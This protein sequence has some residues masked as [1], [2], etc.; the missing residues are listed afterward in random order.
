M[1]GLLRT[2]AVLSALETVSVLALLANLG[3]LHD[4]AVAGVLGPI[5]GALVPV[6]RR[7]GTARSRPDDPD[8][9]WCARARAQRPSHDGQP[10]AGGAQRMS[11]RHYLRRPP[12]ISAAE[13]VRLVEH[14]ALVVD[15]RRQFEWNRVHIPGAVHAPLE[16]LLDRCL[17][18]PDNRLL[19]TFC[20]G[21][22][23][24]AGLRTCWWRT[25]STR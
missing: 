2:L 4:A 9:H 6:R 20:T 23:R 1:T 13:A 25:A 22:I 14:G 5:H 16:E 3:T 12:A 21:G 18:F 24:S 7:H 8:P 15:V 11:L 10:A 17:E 19:I